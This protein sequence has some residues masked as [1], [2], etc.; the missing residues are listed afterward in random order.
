M[1]RSLTLL[2]TLLLIALGAVAQEPTPPSR[3]ERLQATPP[4][5]TRVIPAAPEAAV[6]AIL[7]IQQEAWNQG[8]LERFMKYYWNS[9]QL[10]FISGAEETRGWQG[11]HDRY[12]RRY[13]H[14]RAHMGE[15]SFSELTV[16]PLGPGAAACWGRW[17]LF[18]APAGSPPHES[19]G[20]FTL[21]FRRLPEGWR[22]IHDHTS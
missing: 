3:S 20:R 7:A 18:L 8:D 21:L 4:A 22:I 13:G 15:L 6:R 9:G 10:T 16:V 2:T 14:D 17:H 12:L 1:T 11:A 19:G 5:A